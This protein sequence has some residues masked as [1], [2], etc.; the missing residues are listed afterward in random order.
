MEVHVLLAR[1]DGLGSRLAEPL[2][3]PQRDDDGE[4][5]KDRRRGVQYERGDCLHRWTGGA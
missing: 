1:L 4:Q 5:L 2:R 3:D